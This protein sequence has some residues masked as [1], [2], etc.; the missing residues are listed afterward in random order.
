MKRT[1]F[2]YAVAIFAGVMLYSCQAND[3]TIQRDVESAV[4]TTNTGVQSTV[5]DGVV[6]LTGTVETE[7]AK[8]EAERAVRDVKNVKSVNNNIQVRMNAP[9]VNNNDQTL[10]TR[11][12][13]DLNTAGISGINVSVMNGV[14]TLTGN[15]KRADLTRVMQIAQETNPQRVDNQLTV[16]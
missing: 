3:Q 14:V 12:N 5:N 16:N 1:L 6:T 9:V 8:T 7:Q 10:T 15:V 2:M 13:N 11:I 4:R